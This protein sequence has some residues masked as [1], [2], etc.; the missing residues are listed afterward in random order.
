[1]QIRILTG[2]EIRQ[3]LPMPKA[4]EA[5]RTAFGQFSAG[6]AR[7][8]LRSRLQADKGVMLLMPAFME[9]TNEMAVKLVSIYGGNPGLGLPTVSA[10]VMVFD[11][12]T[13]RP[14]ALMEGDALT[15]LR[16]GAAG[17]LAADLLAR[18]SAS[19]VALFGAGV[20]GRAQLQAVMAVRKIEK[21][22]LMDPV[23]ASAQRLA[24]QIATWPAAPEVVV[25]K[26]PGTAVRTADIILAATTAA[27]PLFDGKDVQPGTHVTGVGS[28]TPEMQEIDAALVAR[29]RVV[30]DSR[31]ACLAEAGDIIQAKAV[32][33]AEIGEIVNGQAPGRL[34]DQEI[35]FFKSVGIAAQDAAAAAAALASAQ[36][37]GLGTVV[38][39]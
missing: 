13:G 22:I 10:L 18:P 26:D 3:A 27:T 39:L 1:M 14:L 6:R 11:P 31:Q 19:R 36:S 28:F 30:V 35:T 20:Q 2:D 7:V 8:P 37:L 16:T 34:D 9:A 38:A 4:I 33:T 15:A 24:A 21:V 12:D 32:I 17:G 5:V 23:G 25:G 29:A